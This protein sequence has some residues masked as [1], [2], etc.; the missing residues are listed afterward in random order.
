MLGRRF[1]GQ[2]LELKTHVPAT[3][4]PILD[5]PNSVKQWVCTWGWGE[6]NRGIWHGKGSVGKWSHPQARLMHGVNEFQIHH[7]LA[8]RYLIV[9]RGPSMGSRFRSFATI[10]EA[11]SVPLCWG[12]FLIGLWSEMWA[13]QRMWLCWS[14]RGGGTKTSVSHRFFLVGQGG[15][16][17]E[18]AI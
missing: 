12:F 3:F 11:G 15:G 1:G 8:L 5:G 4:W 18:R 14:R 16:S 6:E 17:W 2:S 9:A 13:L 10:V 7:P